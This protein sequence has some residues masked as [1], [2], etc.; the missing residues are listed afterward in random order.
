MGHANHDRTG[1]IMKVKLNVPYSERDL[2]KSLGARWD[3]LTK[4]WY[5]YPNSQIA[6]V[7]KWLP[8][9]IRTVAR[10]ISGYEIVRRF[11]ALP[12]R[13]KDGEAVCKFLGIKPK[14]LVFAKSAFCGMC[15]SHIHNEWTLNGEIEL[16]HLW[17]TDKELQINEKEEWLLFSYLEDFKH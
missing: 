10:D 14:K 6:T 17:G 2:A 8:E 4:A 9:E 16:R 11:N 7:A 13:F 1:V 12:S 3:T 5:A 15:D